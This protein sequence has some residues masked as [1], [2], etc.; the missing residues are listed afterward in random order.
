MERR[1]NRQLMARKRKKLIKKIILA[2]IILLLA[3]IFLV[4]PMIGLKVNKIE[5]TN[6]NIP[7][8]FNGFSIAQVSDL[9]LK[10]GDNL[11]W[12]SD[13]IDEIDPDVVFMTGNTFTEEDDQF[14]PALI[15][16]KSSLRA[17]TMLYISMGETETSLSHD[18]KDD[19]FSHLRQNQIYPLDNQK[20]SLVR[21]G[22]HISIYGLSP[23]VQDLKNDHARVT[24]FQVSNDSAN[25][26]L[27]NHPGYFDNLSEMGVDLILSGNRNGGWRRLIFTDGIDYE[28]DT[29][30]IEDEYIKNETTMY[31]SR[32]SSNREGN[33]RIL[34]P[35]QIN[36]IILGR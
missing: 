21:G 7:D 30:Y 29:Q 8:I 25:I 19:L 15:D 32:G 33:I 26:V 24:N 36:E 17:T 20:A 1:Y 6:P 10:K 11:D 5:Y 27:S 31:I 9:Y 3:F 18:Y 23:T 28:Y 35:R 34:N 4:Y 13:K 16:F 2:S 22:S 12:L 14:Y